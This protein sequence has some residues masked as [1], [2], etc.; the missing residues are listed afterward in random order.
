MTP[1]QQT[2]RIPELRREQ[3]SETQ[4]ALLLRLEAARG[5]IPTPFKIWIH[6]PALAEPLQTLGTLLTKGVCLSKKER[7]IAILLIARHWEADYVVETHSREA[8]EAG[9]PEAIIAEI[10][11]GAQPKLADPR[12]RNVC[13]IVGDFV[14]NANTGDSTFNDALAALGHEGLVELILLCGYFTSIG[15]AMKL[16][17]MPLRSKGAAT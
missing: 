5:R 15:L 7:E 10:R 2:S 13:A 9:L 3:L 6:N 12:E 16:Y 17:R 11:S 1:S 8:L 4:S 14:R